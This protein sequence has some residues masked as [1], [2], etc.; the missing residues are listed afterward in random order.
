MF[1]QAEYGDFQD[2]VCAVPQRDYQAGFD[3]RLR[4]QGFPLPFEV[5]KTDYQGHSALAL[6]RSAF[7]PDA[8]VPPS[9]G[10][11]LSQPLELC[12]PVGPYSCFFGEASY[13]VVPIRLTSLGAS[14]HALW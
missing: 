5:R 10:H 12:E 9:A 11:L 2:L 8:V 6:L 7:W 1:R 3:C 13:L 4:Q 14:P